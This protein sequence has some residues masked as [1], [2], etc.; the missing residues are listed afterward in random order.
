MIGW[1]SNGTYGIDRTERQIFDTNID[2]VAIVSPM[3]E[4]ATPIKPFPSF[5]S[6][7]INLVRN[8]LAGQEIK[9][10]ARTAFDKPFTFLQS[11]TTTTWTDRLSALKVV[12][13]PLGNSQFVQIMVQMSTTSPN[14]SWT[15]EIRTIIVS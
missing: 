5:Q 9:V 6:I 4:I 3:M 10:Y 8:L 7:E 11:F 12:K 15:P 1:G 13:N 14:E 2:N